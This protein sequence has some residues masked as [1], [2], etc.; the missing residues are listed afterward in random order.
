LARTILFARP[1]LSKRLAPLI[2][3]SPSPAQE[4]R[5]QRLPV[6]GCRQGRE[7]SFRFGRWPASVSGSLPDGNPAQPDAQSLL[8]C[9]SDS[10]TD[11]PD[12]ESY[13]LLRLSAMQFRQNVKK[14]AGGGVAG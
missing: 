2:L 10:A 5:R 12:V 13:N 14:S 4:C 9:N 6:S 1:E 11:H 7:G 8:L 3:S